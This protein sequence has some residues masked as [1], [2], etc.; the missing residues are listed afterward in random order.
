M[1]F[2]PLII[3]LILFIDTPVVRLM[4]I[5]ITVIRVIKKSIRL[6]FEK[7]FLPLYKAYIKG[8]IK[9]A[10]INSKLVLYKNWELIK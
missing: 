1:L 5:N 4:S 7:A 3:G 2:S 9:N 6:V 8:I 10:D